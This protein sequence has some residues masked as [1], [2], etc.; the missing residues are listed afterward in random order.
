MTFIYS[1]SVIIIVELKVNL[2]NPVDYLLMKALVL[3]NFSRSWVSMN[4]LLC[5]NPFKKK[6]K[7]FEKRRDTELDGVRRM[8][9][10]YSYLRLGQG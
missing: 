2:D 4:N 10:L 6:L 8:V 5:L 3:F 1:K 9:L 7:T